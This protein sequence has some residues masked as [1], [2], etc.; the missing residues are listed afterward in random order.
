[1]RIR[2]YTIGGL[3]RS[4]GVTVETVRYYQRRGLL[5]VPA[6][7]FGGRRRYSEECSQRLRFIKR[8]QQV[9]FS[10]SEI[11]ELLVLSQGNRCSPACGVAERR[12]AD[13]ERRI[14]DLTAMRKALRGLVSAC[15]NNGLLERCPLIDA[16]AAS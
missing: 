1:M 13:I 16:F 2:S 10:L 9:G 15:G 14:D 6:V 3:A 8:A 12:L 4:A 5:P 7:P 11:G